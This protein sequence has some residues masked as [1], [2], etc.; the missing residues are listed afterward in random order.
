[1]KPVAKKSLISACVLTALSASA[2]SNSAVASGITEA[3]KG[4]EVKADFRL[5]LESVSQEGKAE[6]ATALTL[7]SRLGYMTAPYKGL[8]GY[9]EFENI[10]ALEDEYSMPGATSNYP[11]VADPEGSEVNQVFLKYSMGESTVIAGR[12]RIILDNA[13]FVGNVG[14]R[15]N[16]QT[17][18][19]LSLK[20]KVLAESELSYHY[21]TKVNNILGKQGDI[22]AHLLNASYSGIPGKV[23]GYAY[24]IEDEDA[25]AKSSSTIGL[26]YAG[27]AGELFKY[28]VEFAKQSSYKDGNDDIDA[29]YMLLEGMMK[30]GS[31]DLKLGYEVLGADDAYGFQT[32]LATKHAFNGW[33]DTLLSTPKEGI[34]DRYIGATTK[35]AGTKL[36]AV[37]H[38]YSADEGSANYGS[39]INLLAAKKFGDNYTALIKYADYSADDKGSDIQKLWVMGQMSF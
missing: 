33:A 37:Y 5:R 10:T 17:Y 32:P 24:L 29:T 21:V 25:V 36:M 30:A 13:R 18:D 31:V 7:R 11:V 6:D 12:Q 19:A 23:T 35:V 9:L 39:E 1:M 14:W 38:D 22:A 20:S 8:S 27:A 26:R 2:M 28:N 15:Q 16:E 3:I 4:G 34:Q